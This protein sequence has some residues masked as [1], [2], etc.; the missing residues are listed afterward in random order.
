MKMR[1]LTCF[2]EVRGGLAKQ[3]RRICG[4][5]I[6]AVG[7]GVLLRQVATYLLS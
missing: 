4:L 2:P 1:Q 7:S 5:T 3:L 6:V